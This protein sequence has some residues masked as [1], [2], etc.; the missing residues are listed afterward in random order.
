MLETKI[1]RVFR[2][3]GSEAKE[4][5]DE[6]DWA[7][8]TFHPSTVQMVE[9]DDSRFCGLRADNFIVIKG[10]NEDQFEKQMIMVIANHKGTLL[11]KTA[12]YEE[13]MLNG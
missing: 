13:E 4:F 7:V 3:R 12:L 5:S 2:E 11:Y 9:R 8:T 10:W 6:T 1:E